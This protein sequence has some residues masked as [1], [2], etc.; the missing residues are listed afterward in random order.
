VY[1]LVSDAEASTTREWVSG[2]ELGG[3]A[4]E[5]RVGNPN[6]ID[7]GLSGQEYGTL[8]R[9]VDRVFYLSTVATPAI[10]RDAAEAI[11]V[12]GARELI[13][14][15]RSSEALKCAVL[16]SSAA[17]SGDH[18]G[19][20]L[21]EQLNVGQSFRNAAEESL[22]RAER[23]LRSAKEDVPYAVLRPSQ[24]IGD[25]VSGETD[26]FGG[27]Y[28]FI[29]LILSSPQDMPV[30]LPT[31]GDELINMVPLDYVVRVISHVG[32]HSRA[33]GRTFHLSDPQPLTVRRALELIAQRAGK[34]LASRHIPANLTKALLQAPGVNLLSKNQRAFLD[35][36]C[37]KIH[38][39]ARNTEDLL[40]E[41]NFSC[42]PFE[43]Y[44]DKIVDFVKQRLQS[45]RP[46]PEDDQS[47]H[48]DPLA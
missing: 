46:R 7:F 31:R 12:G 32:A 29:T 34:S 20:F 10:S 19:T 45:R 27:P 33:P 30:P 6:A 36:V 17:V 13:E 1:A 47:E 9:E 48:E 41:T 44:V 4:I 3:S 2:V 23:L 39:D 43:T 28:P 37:T 16:L 11:N 42:P 26:E 14:F 15:G 5:V 40:S 24:I 25:S 38:Y 8:A 22:A 21:E 35:A 18:T